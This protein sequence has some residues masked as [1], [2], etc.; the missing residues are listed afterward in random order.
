[1]AQVTASNGYA[2][3]L[4]IAPRAG[5]T[6]TMVQLQGLLV[7]IKLM[8]AGVHVSTHSFQWASVLFAKVPHTDHVNVGWC[9]WAKFS[10]SNSE[11]L[12]LPNSPSPECDNFG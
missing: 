10:A 8:W 5:S 7:Q 4:P 9:T 6:H 11:A 12:F 1:M 3:F 2:L